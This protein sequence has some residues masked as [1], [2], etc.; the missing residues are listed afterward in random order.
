MIFD[1]EAIRKGYAELSVEFGEKG[2]AILAG[3]PV[4][5]VESAL[6]GEKPTYTEKIENLLLS[7]PKAF[8]FYKDEQLDLFKRLERFI[9][10]SG[11]ASKAASAIGTSGST[12]SDIRNCKYRGDVQQFFT[13]F[14]SYL[15]LK[16]EKKAQI[17][18]ASDYV[19]T[20][21]S[22]YMYQVIRGV[23]IAGECEIITGDT[24]VGK[25]RTITKYASDYPENTVV[26]TPTYADSSVIGIMK[27]IAAQ[28]G[29]S[30]LN[31]LHD[32]NS[33]V[34]SRLHDGMLIIIDEAQHLKFPAIDHLRSLSDIF[35]DRGETMG[36]CFVGNP[37]FMRHFD[38]KKIAVTGQVFNR[39]NLRPYIKA[40]DIKIEDIKL[41][42]P[43]LV[44]QKKNAEI[45]FLYAIAQTNGE[46]IRRAIKFYST[47]YNMDGGNV[48]I[49]RLAELAQMGN[50]RL[51]NIGGII[52]RL[53]EE[54]A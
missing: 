26:V 22:E 12:I 10:D 11:S 9:V 40:A 49:E 31:R 7:R 43:E 1:L 17:Y 30:G 29:I 53:R 27:L 3:I 28:L 24:G 48:G 34:L 41:L 21:V 33:A 47:A 45:K 50:L 35:T 37:S 5:F 39:A 25:S 4:K 36:I 52:K 23:H 46:G 51:A 19:P 13:D 14:S 15:A 8:E 42:F 6:N 44:S 54:A 2:A 38:E 16:D 32:L 20:S 18:K